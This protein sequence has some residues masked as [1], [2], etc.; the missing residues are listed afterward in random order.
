MHLCVP[1]AYALDAGRDLAQLPGTWKRSR[2]PFSATTPVPSDVT[3]SFEPAGR[4]NAGSRR[5]PGEVVSLGYLPRG[6]WRSEIWVRRRE[7]FI[8]ADR[9]EPVLVAG[10]TT[11]D[12]C[13]AR[14]DA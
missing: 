14:L 8:D 10:S 6:V 3:M 7:F 9:E 11:L 12:L 4:V 2:S 1:S 13:P 5:V